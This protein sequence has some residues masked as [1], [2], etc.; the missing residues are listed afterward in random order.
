V[1]WVLT[2]VGFAFLVIAHEAGHFA[3]AKA[4]GMRVE[5][6][7]L[8]FPPKLV[9]KRIGE[10]EYGIGAI[11]LGG[12]V[13]ITGMNPEELEAAERGVPGRKGTL[14]TQLESADSGSVT[15]ASLE[16][17]GPV[18][19]EIIDRAYYNQPVW[20]RIVVIGAGPAVNIAIAFAILFVLFIKVPVDQGF[21]VDKIEDTYKVGKVEHETPAA[22][23][24][25]LGDRIVS[26]D[27]VTANVHNVKAFSDVNKRVAAAG[28]RQEKLANKT[29]SHECAGRQTNGCTSSAPVTIE[30]I[31]DGQPLTLHVKP[32]YDKNAG[33]RGRHRLGFAF[34]GVGTQTAD[35]NPAQAAYLSLDRMWFV[36][37]R[38]V[39]TIAHLFNPEDRKQ[40]SGPVGTSRALNEAV[41]LDTRTALI[42]LALISL[43]L[44]IV[45]LFPFLPLDGGHIF[46]S[47]VE[48]L[49]GRRVSFATMERASV[50]GFML[51]MILFAV[52]LTNDIG[53]LGGDALS[54]R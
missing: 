49:Q 6:F 41:G 38:T 22:A 5:R 50:V 13:K 40:L 16:G 51:V 31:R 9:S 15:P 11:P 26:I 8:F 37:T 48:K 12:F 44:G 1:T 52:G 24:L 43:S 45:N 54:G 20:K 34:D 35:Q 25:Q 33:P 18:P 19:Q 3:A 23:A 10:T 2:V 17:D 4:V 29:N 27:G 32:F 39:S 42:V 47:L 30:L 28:T 53:R 7:F 21:R 14:L 36:T 46:W